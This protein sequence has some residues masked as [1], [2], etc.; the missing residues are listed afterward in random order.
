[1]V[2]G[3]E[4]EKVVGSMLAFTPFET[5]TTEYSFVFTEDNNPPDIQ[6]K[7]YA[8][9][10][11][12]VMCEFG[13]TDKG[14]ILT[15]HPTSEDPLC[16]WS[17]GSENVSIN[18]N[19]SV[20]LLRFAL[21]IGYG[22]KTLP[23]CTSAIHSSCITYRDKAILFLGESG[24]GKSTHTRLWTKNIT[25]ARLLNDDSPILR[26]HDNKLWAYGSPWSGKT[27]CYKN[28]KYEVIASVRLSQGPVN[29]IRKLSILEAY[30]ALHPSFSPGFAYDET[31]YENIGD[32]INRILQNTSVYHLECLPNA[33][34]A[35]MAKNT[36]FED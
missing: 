35:M 25:G 13:K 32:I 4:L 22:L 33:A 20:R 28:E 10:Y 18:G 14:Y 24:T 16:L 11:E 7:L 30:G 26:Y 5:D 21:W 19:Y 36:I 9:S 8:F 27:A 3:E 17:D 15:L 31:L 23:L 29:R 12:D 1:M 2:S 6:K 34:A